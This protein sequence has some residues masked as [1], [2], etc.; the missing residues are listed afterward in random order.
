MPQGKPER[1]C[2]L[3]RCWGHLSAS[4]SL[5]SSPQGE[6][7]KQRMSFPFWPWLALWERPRPASLALRAIHLQLSDVCLTERAFAEAHPQ[8]PERCCRLL[9]CWCHLS[10]SHSLSSSPQGEPGK[11]RASFPFWPWLALW[12]QPTR[13]WRRGDAFQQT[14]KE[15]SPAKGRPLLCNIKE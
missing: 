9:R 7:G 15:A 4:H 6:P 8:G 14:T 10:A 11:Q 1:C 12:E 5:S 13:K 3:S 2:H